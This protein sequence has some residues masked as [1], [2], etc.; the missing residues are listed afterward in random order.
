MVVRYSFPEGGWTLETLFIFIVLRLVIVLMI[1][2]FLGIM[3]EKEIIWPYWLSAI[4]GLLIGVLVGVLRKDF[5]LGLQISAII[6][7]A[8]IFGIKLM[9]RQ[10]QLFVN[11]DKHQEEDKR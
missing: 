1:S 4:C 5:Q 6:I 8:S 7:L 11:Y 9:R 2:F 10:R 3:A